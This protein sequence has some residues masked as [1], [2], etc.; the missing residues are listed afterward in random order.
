[1]RYQFFVAPENE[2]PFLEQMIRYGNKIQSESN[3]APTLF[4]DIVKIEIAK[5]VI[6][7]GID[8]VT[9]GWST[10]ARLNKEKELI[11]IYLSAHPLDNFKLEISTF[12]NTR[13]ADF[14][15]LEKLKDKDVTCAGIVTSVKNAITKNGKPYGSMTVEDYT[16][17]YSIVLFGKDY[18]TFRNYFFEGYPLLMKGTVAENTWKNKELEFRIK[19]IQLLSNAKDELIHNLS[20]R[21]PLEEVNDDFIENIKKHTAK[22]GKVLI[23]FTIHDMEEKMSIEMFSRSQRVE[24]TNQLIDYLQQTPELEFKVS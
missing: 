15:E 18:E 13:L 17:S 7:E 21:I 9:V 14:R 8:P 10:L 24:L 16:D 12:C 11:G 3:S 5:P 19:S 4:G 22:P 1:M 2:L 20:I 23:K 6:P